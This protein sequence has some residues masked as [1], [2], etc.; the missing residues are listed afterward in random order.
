MG[1]RCRSACGS[2]APEPGS[3]LRLGLHPNTGNRLTATV[4]KAPGM[5]RWPAIGNGEG[6]LIIRTYADEFVCTVNGWE[7]KSVNFTPA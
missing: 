5:S 6:L 7:F 1:P 2:G 3:D 4:S